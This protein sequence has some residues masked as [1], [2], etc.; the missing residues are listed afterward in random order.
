MSASNWITTST[1]RAIIMMGIGV[2]G[3]SLMSCGKTA[4]VATSKTLAQLAPGHYVVPAKVDI[5][6]AQDDTGSIKEVFQPIASQMP[7]FLTKLESQG[8]DYHFATTPLTQERAVS[9]AMASCHDGNWGSLW[10]S[11]YPGASISGP[12]TLASSVFRTREQ[13]TGFLSFSDTTNVSNGQE[14]GFEI[15]RRALTDGIEQTNFLRNDAMLVVLVV[16][17]GED[18][19]GVNKCPRQVDGIMENCPDGS[20]ESSFQFYKTEFQD[21]KVDPAQVR[22]FSAVADGRNNCLGGPSYYG[23]RYIRMAKELGSNSHVFNICTQSV[24]QVISSLSSQLHSTR[25]A[26]RTRYLFIDHEPEPG[27]IRV[28]K[29]LD[30]NSETPQEIPEDPVNG[31]TYVGLVSNVYT[32]DHPVEMNLASGYAI[33]LHGSAKLIGSESADVI[34]K[35]KGAKDAAE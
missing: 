2:L 22:F 20:D 27:T 25:L 9:Q 34:F 35:N 15:I 7:G 17:N 32:I 13:Y 10:C 29:Y 12:G 28:V 1:R 33:E 21:L 24:S 26:M 18:T 16:G 11:P 5:L 31:W 8:W 19:S 23:G 14:N 3:M 30:G 6:L 4:F